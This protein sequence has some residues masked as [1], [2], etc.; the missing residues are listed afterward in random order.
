MVIGFLQFGLT[1]LDGGAT[2]AKKQEVL[3]LINEALYTY[4]PKLQIAGA[5]ALTS[6]AK[7]GNC[8]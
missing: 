7:N 2:I 1:K 5:R 6:I 4:T 3:P 8:Y